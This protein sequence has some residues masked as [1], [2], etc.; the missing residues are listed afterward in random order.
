MDSAMG[1]HD[2]VISGPPQRTI[3]QALKCA[4]HRAPAG[5][6][7]DLLQSPIIAGVDAAA[8]SADECVS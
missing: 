8:H 5:R 2:A 7:G 6:A 1:E 3:H 4:I